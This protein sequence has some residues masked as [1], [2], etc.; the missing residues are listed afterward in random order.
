MLNKTERLMIKLHRYDPW[1]ESVEG[2]LT[3]SVIVTTNRRRKS[4]RVIRGQKAVSA[5]QGARVTHLK[6]ML[7]PK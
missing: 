5:E 3:S 1:Q 2:S 4:G 7:E 6:T